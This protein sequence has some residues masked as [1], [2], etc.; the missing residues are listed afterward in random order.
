L[1]NS[2]L[3]IEIDERTKQIKTLTALAEEHE[4]TYA[5]QPIVASVLALPGPPGSGK[6]VDVCFSVTAEGWNKTSGH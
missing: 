3:N 4:R 5:I 1:S 6:C 2:Y